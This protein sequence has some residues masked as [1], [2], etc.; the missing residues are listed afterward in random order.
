MLNH[1]WNQPLNIPLIEKSSPPKCPPSGSRGFFSYL[2]ILGWCTVHPDQVWSKSDNF[3]QCGVY[4]WQLEYLLNVNI[5][6]KLR[7]SSKP[8][9][10]LQPIRLKFFTSFLKSWRKCSMIKI[11]IWKIADHYPL[12]DK[13]AVP[14]LCTIVHFHF[15]FLSFASWKIFDKVAC[16]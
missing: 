4:H 3:H 13:P 5:A 1:G 15:S 16:M 7:G 9:K 14:A 2:G 11:C 8:R 6:Q 10:K 12:Q